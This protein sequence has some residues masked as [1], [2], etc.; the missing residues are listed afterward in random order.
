LIAADAEF[1]R[2]FALDPHSD[3]FR[4]VAGLALMPFLSAF[5]YESVKYFERADPTAGRVLQ[6]NRDM[7]LWSRMRMKLTEDK[8]KSSAAVLEDVEELI[9]INSGWFLEGHRGIRRPFRLIQ[10]DVGLTFMNN[11]M[12]YTTHVAFLNLGLTKEALSDSSLNMNTLGPFLHD[13]MVNVGQYVKLLTLMLD[14]GAHTSAASPTPAP[15]R[16]RNRDMKLPLLYKAVAQRVAPGRLRTGILLTWMLSQI[17]TARIIVPRIAG[18]NEI[19]A[20]KI[21]FVSLY[22]N[23]LSLQKLLNEESESS[24]MTPSASELIAHVLAEQSVINVLQA[25]DLRND[26]VHYGVR[27]R[28]SQRLSSRLPLCGLVDTNPRS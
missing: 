2:D 5:A 23:A 14:V 21:R 8:Y 18:G 27:K 15:P 6:S 16:Q 12:I 20:L 7:L 4:A 11:E 26:L 13:R 28:M 17:N 9:A 24:F 1:F 22:Q 19:A 25:K 3:D 10:P